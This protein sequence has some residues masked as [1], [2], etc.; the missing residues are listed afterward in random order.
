[1]PDSRSRREATELAAVVRVHERRRRKRLLRILTISVLVVV[2]LLVPATLIPAPDPSTLPAVLLAGA[3][4]LAALAMLA[5][6]WVAGSGFALLGGLCFAIG[7]AIFAKSQAQGGVDLSDLRI[8]DLFVLPIALSGV[9][10]GRRGPLLLGG[11]TIAF[12][13]ASLLLLPHTPPLQAYWDGHYQFATLGSVYDVIAVALVAQGLVAAA[14]WLGADSVRRALLEATRA[15]E[16]EQANRRIQAQA[17]EVELQRLRLQAGI[18]QIQEVHTAVAR[19]FW[20]TRAN[21]PDGELLPVATSLNLLLDR[22]GRLTRE[23]GEQARAFAAAHELAMALRRLSAGQTYTPPAFTG[24]PLDEVLMELTRLRDVPPPRPAPAGKVAVSPLESA[25]APN[26]SPSAPA[27]TPLDTLRGNGGGRQ[28]LP[29]SPSQP[30][31]SPPWPGPAPSASSIPTAPP[32]PS[33]AASGFGAATNFGASS[34]F[35]TPI[36]PVTPV[37]VPLERQGAQMAQEMQAAAEEQGGEPAPAWPDLTPS[38]PES[39]DERLPPW[40]LTQR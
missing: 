26:G 22:L 31:L 14:G 23:S 29:S 9:V 20:D 38:L 37:T 12:T 7:W 2:A 1:M 16:L 39:D 32:S 18:A 4:T 21:I 25:A 30:P 40:L 11:A 34:L 10:L 3:F 36:S 27:F 33:L 24:T 5:A 17:R 19:G 13:I 15:D 8:Y 35:Q 6:D 28:V